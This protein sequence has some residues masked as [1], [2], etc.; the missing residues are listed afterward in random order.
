MFRPKSSKEQGFVGDAC[1]GGQ[2]Q[3]NCGANCTGL[4]NRALVH[5]HVKVTSLIPEQLGDPPWMEMG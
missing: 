2:A 1:E 4:H 5:L 3:A